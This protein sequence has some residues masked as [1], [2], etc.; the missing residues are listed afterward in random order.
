MV[1][2]RTRNWRILELQVEVT[3][4]PLKNKSGMGISMPFS[5]RPLESPIQRNNLEIDH[6][7]QGSH[8]RHMMKSLQETK[9]RGGLENCLKK[10]S[11]WS[12]EALRLAFDALESGYKMSEVCIHYRIPRSSLR[13]DYVGK[14]KSRKIDP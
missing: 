5:I 11:L 7:H 2:R 1:R 6:Y 14:M 12:N 3:N 10:S 13:E 9:G 4:I 8:F